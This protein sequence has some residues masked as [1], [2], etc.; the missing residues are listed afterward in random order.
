MVVVLL[1]GITPLVL[2]VIH[3]HV[4]VLLFQGAQVELVAQEEMEVMVVMVH[5]PE[6]EE[7]V[8]RPVQVLQVPLVELSMVEVLL[9][10][11]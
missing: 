9:D 8:E 11:T 5:Q 2:L 7:L 6:R 10:I 4:E 1:G 3:L